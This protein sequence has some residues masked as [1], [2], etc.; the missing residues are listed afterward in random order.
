MEHALPASGEA[1]GAPTI[2]PGWDM[3]SYKYD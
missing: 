2:I 1:E 3:L